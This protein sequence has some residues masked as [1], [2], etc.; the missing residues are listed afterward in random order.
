[1]QGSI[2]GP[3]LFAVFINDLPNCV[4]SSVLYLFADDTKCLKTISN[5]TD[6]QCLQHDLGNLS[7][8]SHIN[9]LLFNESKSVH[10]HFGKSFGSHTYMLNGATITSTYCTKDVWVY[11]STNI[12]F[13]HHYEKITAGCYRSI[14]VNFHH[15]MYLCQETAISYPGE[16]STDLMFPA[17]VA[18]F[19]VKR[20]YNPWTNSKKSYQIHFEWLQVIIQ[21][22]PDS[23]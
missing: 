16:I 6:I 17:V 14:T 22:L 5:S 18:S 4:S 21:I 2:L 13:S 19:S 20:Y 10:Q 15:P 1:M 23:T 3:L 7:N 12:N 11:L 8:W 9:K